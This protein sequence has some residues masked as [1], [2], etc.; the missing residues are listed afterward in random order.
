VVA[1]LNSMNVNNS[2][3]LVRIIGILQRLS[4][5]YAVVLIIH[6]TTKYG[7]HKKRVIGYVTIMAMILLYLAYMLTF[8]KPEIGCPLSKNLTEFCNFGAYIDRMIFTKSHMIYP[9]DP[10]GLF[11]N[12]TAIT[13]V[14]FGYLFCLAMKDYKNSTIKTLIT[15]VLISLILGVVSYP[16]TK[17]MPLNKKI[18]SISYTALTIATSGLTL[19]FFVIVV[20]ILP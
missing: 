12:L 15:W 20:D 19:A 16:L 18:Y 3:F 14:Y 1:N 10:E 7:D 17:L 4:I 5:C 6:V 9:N 8:D 2:L 13:T 11:T